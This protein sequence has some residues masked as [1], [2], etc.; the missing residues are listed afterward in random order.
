MNSDYKFFLEDI[1]ERVRSSQYEA[2]KVV[3]KELIALYWDIGRRIIEK[4]KEFGWGKAIVETLA[5]DLQKEFPGIKGFSS[6]NLWYMR[7][8]YGEYQGS[9]ILQPLVGEISWAKHLVIMSQCKKE[10][11][12]VFYINMTKK[13]GWTKDVLIHQIENQSYDK[14]LL[15][16]TSFDKTVPVNIRNQA[17]LAV[18]D[19]Y[20]FDFLELGDEHLENELERALMVNVRRFLLEL[21]G[22]FCFITNQHRIEIDGREYFVDILLYHRK[23]RCLVAIELKIGDFK[24]EYAGKMQFYLSALN[25]RDKL[26]EENPAIGII[27]CKSKSRTVVEYALKDVK[28]PIGV[29]TYSLNKSLPKTLKKYLPSSKDWAKKL[30]IVK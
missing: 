11:A 20:T 14:T 9:L 25:D 30:N 24:P 10:E 7:Q 15:N 19:E 23:L 1:K 13:F 2:L 6:Q 21:G 27:I 28:K 22:N 17:K 18:K 3:N 26:E 5:Q 4:Q 29:S 8:F 16:Q 12:R